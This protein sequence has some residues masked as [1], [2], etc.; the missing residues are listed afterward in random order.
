DDTEKGGDWVLGQS[1]KLWNKGV[2]GKIAAVPVAAV[3]GL[4]KGLGWGV[5]KVGNAVAFAYDKVGGAIASVG[6]KVWKGLGKVAKGVAS[7]AKAVGNGIKK[8]FSGW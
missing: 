6:D 2:L 5:K 8:I 7:G 1:K 4:V 3:G